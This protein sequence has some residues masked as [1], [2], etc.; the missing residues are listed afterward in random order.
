MEALR[1]IDA[2]EEVL[3]KYWT[4]VGYFNS[5][6]ELGKT[7]TL[8][9]DDIASNI[10]RYMKRLM[11]GDDIRYAGILNELTS[12]LSSTAVVKNLKNLENI[13]QKGEEKTK[14][15]KKKDNINYAVDIL[16]ATNMISVGV[17][18]S[19]LDL[20]VVSG[21]PKQTSEYIQA[22]SRV[23]RKYPGLVFTLYNASKT[24]DRSH[25]ELF[26]PYHNTFYK[27]VEPTSITSFSEQARERALHAVFI[28]MVRH[29]LK[30]N[31]DEQAKE[32]N[33]NLEGLD[34]AI[35]FILKR[36][37]DLD[38]SQKKDI[39]NNTKKELGQIVNR[40]ID[41]IDT[42]APDEEVHYYLKNAD[43][44]LLVPF[45]EDD[46]RNAFPT[47]QSMRN[48]DNQAG[49]EIIEFGDENNE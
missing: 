44:N 8:V 26:Y 2:S 42:A 27:Y 14:S 28:S 32:F 25:Y 39:M 45:F 29:I 15:G 24:R 5:I 13:Y 41:K 36:A 11:K 34:E 31:G 1:F 17:D 43:K 16:L 47:M 10:I 3:D 46:C 40:W 37:E 7:S 9:K 18:V 12:R 48:V 30:L 4:L 6:R 33:K 38:T 35:N 23:G 20:M 21:Q 22:T 49:A 19:R